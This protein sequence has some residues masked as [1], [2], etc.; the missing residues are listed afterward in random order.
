MTKYKATGCGRFILVLLILAPLAYIGASYYL[1]QDGIGNIK[2][3]IGMGD[4]P[5]EEAGNSETAGDGE[6]FS[7]TSQKLEEELQ[8]QKKE[9]ERLK[10]ENDSLKNRIEELESEVTSLKSKDDVNQ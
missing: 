4:E 1:G 7:E 3:L 10:A 9:A 6:V 5:A 8:E 2:N